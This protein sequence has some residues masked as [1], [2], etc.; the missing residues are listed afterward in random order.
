[1]PSSRST[2]TTQRSFS[3]RRPVSRTLSSPRSTLRSVSRPSRRSEIDER[4]G[5]PSPIRFHPPITWSPRPSMSPHPTSSA[6]ATD[7]PRGPTLSSVSRAENQLAKSEDAAR[8]RPDAG[9]KSS[10]THHRKASSPATT[11]SS[12]GRPRVEPN[13]QLQIGCPIQNWPRSSP[14][15]SFPPHER[16]GIGTSEL[17]RPYRPGIDF[18]PSYPGQ[19]IDEI[20]SKNK[21]TQVER[22]NFFEI[23]SASSLPNAEPI[24]RGTDARPVSRTI[25]DLGS[26][27]SF[28][29]PNDVGDRVVS[30]QV[31]QR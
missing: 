22:A 6:Y 19:K 2:R 8:N 27:P 28:G 4:R 17:P 31:A 26:P 23:C 13:N 24:S 18:L 3:G 21:V 20:G 16:S 9:D 5:D 1:L 14:S 15:E 25:V 30:P 12:H 7:Q 11:N 10:P 29:F